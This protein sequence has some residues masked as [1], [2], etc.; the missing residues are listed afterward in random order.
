MNLTKL[1]A[2]LRRDEGWSASAYQ[3]HL[4]FWTIGYGFLIDDRKGGFLPR[5]IGEA[6]LKYAA[7]A[8]WEALV[9][10][11]AWIE[12]QPEDVQI[13]LANMAYQMGVNGVLKFK[14]MLDALAIGDRQTAA[15]EALDSAW[16]QQTPERA[17]RVTDLIRGP[18]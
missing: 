16:A 10:A 17:K 3:D 9:R 15:I 5:Q 11:R 6:W 12:D 4:G 1:L 8:R 14:K 7:E 13:A 2:D 18:T